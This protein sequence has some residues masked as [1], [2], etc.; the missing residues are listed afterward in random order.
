MAVINESRLMAYNTNK[1]FSQ[2]DIIMLN[3]NQNFENKTTIFLSHK[4]DEIK[5]LQKTVAFLKE[6]GVDVYV[7]WLDDSMPAYTNEETAYRLKDTIKKSNKFILL[8]TQAAIESKWCNW[9]LGIGDVLKYKDHIA[10][11]PVNQEDRN[12]TGSEYLK[13]YPRIEYADGDW[14]YVATK[15]YLPSGYYVIFPSN[16]E[17]HQVVTLKNWLDGR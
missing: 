3:E 6:E 4:H 13:I 8:A 10:L 5:L 14:Y 2:D 16:D 15:E 12:F 9:E 1:Y 7:D 17:T 11:L